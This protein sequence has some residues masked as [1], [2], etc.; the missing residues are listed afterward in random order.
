M[1]SILGWTIYCKCYCIVQVERYWIKIS[2]VLCVKFYHYGLIDK[3][4]KPMCE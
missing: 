2:V 4:I 3:Y 1:D